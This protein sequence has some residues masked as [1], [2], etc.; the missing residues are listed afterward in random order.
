MTPNN[1]PAAGGHFFLALLCFCMSAAI[2]IVLLVT[3]LVIGVS[4][5]LGSFTWS[6]LSVGLLFALAAGG[7]YL[8]SLKAR[9]EQLRSRMET[10]YD[11]ARLFKQTYDWIHDKLGFFIRLR[12][13]LRH[14]E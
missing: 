5:L 10:I 4:E 13:E 6:A 2:A 14:T 11:V 7:V 3:A 8:F 12:D 1:K 9:A